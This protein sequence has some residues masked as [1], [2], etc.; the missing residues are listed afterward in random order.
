MSGQE[1]SAS[2]SAIREAEKVE[3]GI[4][5]I[6]EYEMR[7]LTKINQSGRCRQRTRSH[8]VTYQRIFASPQRSKVNDHHNPT[9]HNAHSAPRPNK[10][11]TLPAFRLNPPKK[12]SRFYPSSIFCGKSSFI[13]VRIPSEPKKPLAQPGATV[14][15]F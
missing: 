1:L 5:T 14:S 9:D 6:W 12:I 15:S 2:T 8:S 7:V 13:R 4:W 10:L 3:G 11:S